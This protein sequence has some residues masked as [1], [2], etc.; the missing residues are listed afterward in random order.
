MT[1]ITTVPNV[2]YTV[3]KTNGDVIDVHNPSE[4]PEVMHIEKTKSLTSRRR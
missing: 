3:T 1:A 4:L 2:G